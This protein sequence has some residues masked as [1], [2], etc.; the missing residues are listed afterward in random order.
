[1]ITYAERAC[2][3]PS[4]LRVLTLVETY[5]TRVSD[6]WGNELRCHEVAR[7]VKLVVD[8]EELVE[9]ELDVLD[10]K[11]GPIE[12]SWLRFSDGV[13]L[14]PYAPGRM[15]AVQ[16]VDPIVGAAYW[17]GAPRSDIRQ[18]IVDRLVLEMRGIWHTA[19]P[20]RRPVKKS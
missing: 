1:M 8:H 16:I 9:H 7:A 17:P 20:T 19:A 18:A 6:T 2:F 11:C 10:G 4:H 13:I 14:D 3:R 12:H 15:P 5:I